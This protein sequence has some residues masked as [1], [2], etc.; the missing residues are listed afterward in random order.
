MS[1]IS[2]Y[3]L[4]Q[5]INSL[6][7]SA[8]G[9]GG[10][11][12]IAQVLQ[13]GNNA[14]NETILNL[15]GLEF[16]AGSGGGITFEDGT[17]QFTAPVG[18]GGVANPMTANLDASNFNITNIGLTDTF[19]L[20]NIVN[21]STTA[22]VYVNYG[23]VVNGND[24][25]FAKIGT[26]VDAE[27][28]IYMVI[29]CLDSGFKQ[30]LTLQI[31]GLAIK[32]GIRVISHITESDTLIFNNIKYGTDAGGVINYLALSC[33]TPSATCEFAVYQN[34][35]D[36]GSGLYPASSWFVP[37]SSASIVVLP[38]IYTEIPLLANTTGTS[39]NW[40]VKATASA[41]D[42]QTNSLATNTMRS[43]AGT[44]ITAQNDILMDNNNLKQV[45]SIAVDNI[46]VNVGSEIQS[47][48]SI[49]LGANQL[50]N[51]SQIFVD[52]ISENTP[53]NK[54]QVNNVV[55]MNN[56]KIEDIPNPVATLD[57]VNKQYVDSAIAGFI[58]NPLTANLDGASTYRGVNFVNPVSAQD[59]ATKDYVDSA[60]VGGVQNPM[61][62]NLDGGNFNISNVA[63]MTANSIQN[64]NGSS[65]M[66]SKGTF[67]HG[68]LASGNFDVGGDNI[69]FAPNNLLEF[70]NFGATTTYLEY[71]Q[72]SAEFTYENSAQVR[73]NNNTTQ[74][75]NTGSSCSFS[76]GGTLQLYYNPTLASQNEELSLLN[77]LGTGTNQ[78]LQTQ[79][80]AN[81]VPNIPQSLNP[82]F[83]INLRN[84]DVSLYAPFTTGLGWNNSSDG[85]TIPLIESDSI[86]G[87]Y[88]EPIGLN[89]NQVNILPYNSYLCGVGINNASV[90]GGWI[91]SGS[92]T[93]ELVYTLTGLIDQS[94]APPLIVASVGNSFNIESIRIPYT[95]WIFANRDVETGIG[96]SLKLN[97]PVGD[98][99][100][101]QD[102]L[103]ARV[104][105]N[106]I[107]IGIIEMA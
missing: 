25:D 29:R 82:T 107:Q 94:F 97:I 90:N 91:C 39:G 26:G 86:S 20:D 51:V 101:T 66:F 77:V 36:W 32:S 55:S 79:G 3:V 53:A 106:K 34:Q 18:G 46:G 5:K 54:I 80:Q 76:A 38:T 7:Q 14:S 48:A 37:T 102:P 21:N 67:Q 103:N 9:G 2:N 68:G 22:P 28:S 33:I 16:Q 58:T 31:G 41:N 52:S 92:A 85:S 72:A 74:A 35:Q 11:Q 24:Y 59:L 88:G 1:G 69:R 13:T 93:I 27:G 8:G 47:T 45:N 44:T 99:I 10:N 73:F 71:N 19:Y 12:N 30:I 104:N 6:L 96:L 75:F 62:A 42:T 61:V 83:M 70:K 17:T 78:I 49:N 84:D 87:K 65:T 64:V 43:L 40:Y 89:N 63:F 4:N 81:G 23:A 50:Q 95:S 100:D 15:G 56:N 105:A 60:G 98:S 57:A